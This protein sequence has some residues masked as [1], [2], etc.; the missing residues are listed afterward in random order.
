LRRLPLSQF[1]EYHI[2]RS[3]TEALYTRRENL[4]FA[5]VNRARTTCKKLPRDFRFRG[6]F[7]IINVIVLGS[8][9]A[10]GYV[11]PKIPYQ[12]GFEGVFP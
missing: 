4:W 7:A 8:L 11:V 12:G 9:K 1:A 5:V 10:G 6:T 3:E 2:S